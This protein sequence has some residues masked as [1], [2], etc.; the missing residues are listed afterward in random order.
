MIDDDEYKLEKA[1]MV[2]FNFLGHM[3]LLLFV[4]LMWDVLLDRH[5]NGTIHVKAWLQDPKREFKGA[6]N[7][8]NL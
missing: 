7:M 4:H 8:L 2:G 1:L 5:L 3:I 6:V